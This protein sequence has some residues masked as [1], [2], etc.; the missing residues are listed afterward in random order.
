MTSLNG[1][2]I[3]FIGLG[4]MG[5]PMSLN[6]MNAGAAVSVF[7]VVPEA[8]SRQ[9]ALGMTAAASPAAAAETAEVVVVMVSDT[10]SVEAV[11]LGENGVVGALKPGTLVIDMGTTAV[12]ATRRFAAAVAAKGCQYVDAPVSGGS[13]G[14]EAGNLTI[15]A[16]GSDAAIARA[17][18]ILEVL[19]GRITHVGDNGAGQVAKAA[20]Q[21][22]VG[23]NIVAAAEALT[24]ARRAGVDPERVRQALTGGF[25]DSRILELHGLR[26]TS[27][28]FTP[29]GKVTTQHKD[30][31]QALDLAAEL[32]FDL[33]ATR[34][35]R[36]MCQTVMDQ[37][38]G[39]L[40]HAALIKALG[41]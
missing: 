34:L 16:G 24:L 36:E 11:L 4:L 37:G 8:L 5:R 15:M 6:L 7:D 25:A 23:I 21:V 40:D 19:G 31:T 10:P 3:G 18:P 39:D 13:V 33:P 2:T 27:G 32:G 22:I 12:P 1:R 14:A 20:N 9:A 38:D 30:M 35:T 29:G 26:M 17:M 41:E 28:D